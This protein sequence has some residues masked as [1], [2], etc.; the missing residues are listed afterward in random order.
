MRIT[1]I[2]KQLKEIQS[3]RLNLEDDI[4]KGKI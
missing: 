1:N 4:K 3:E 2:E